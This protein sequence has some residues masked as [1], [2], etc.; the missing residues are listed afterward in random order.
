[1]NIMIGMQFIRGAFYLLSALFIII[2]WK[3]SKRSLELWLGFAFFIQIA[4]I[5][6]IV[7]YWLPIGLRI[8]HAIELCIDSFVQAFIY[9]EILF[10]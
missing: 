3:H 4:A 6:L 1:M 2:L 10:K 8:P 7:G 9:G 5:P